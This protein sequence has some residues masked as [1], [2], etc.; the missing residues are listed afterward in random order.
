M[1]ELFV[2]DSNV[3]ID[4]YSRRLQPSE[5]E[6]II[7][8]IEQRRVIISLVTE[9][10][11]V[12]GARSVEE[13]AYIQQLF[14]LMKREPFDLTM[15]PLALECASNGIK[16]ADAIIGATAMFFNVTLITSDL[17]GFG[18]IPGLRLWVPK[19]LYRPR[20]S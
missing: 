17:R 4:L 10:E 13:K 8:I 1:N 20:M 19:R 16:A 15:L 6:R 9:V 18:K 3:F 14:S 12:G 7:D 2:T 5:E 11:A